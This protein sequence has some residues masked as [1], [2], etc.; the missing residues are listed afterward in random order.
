MIS[1]GAEDETARL[2]RLLHRAREWERRTVNNIAVTDTA[3]GTTLLEI[4][5]LAAD[6]GKS[7]VAIRDSS[8]N[9]LLQ[10]DTVSGWGLAAPTNAYPVYPFLPLIKATTTTF[11]EMWLWAG[12]P[13]TR[14]VEWAYVAG[15]EFSDTF[16]ECR[17]EWAPGFSQPWTVVADST[18]QSNDDVSDSS[19]VYTVRSGTFTLPIAAAGQFHAIRIMQRRL[20]VGTGLNAYCTPVYLNAI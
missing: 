10:N 17:L 11:A 1:P 2:D 7:L 19:T 14:T 15:T 3:S 12:F 6:P 16:S 4:T 9:V 20:P 5:P 18:F 13:Y 8:G